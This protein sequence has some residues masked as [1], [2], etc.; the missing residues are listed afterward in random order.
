MKDI[1][2]LALKI[3]DSL[4]PTAGKG[5]GKNYILTPNNVAELCTRFLAAYTEGQEPISLYPCGFKELRRLVI[6]NGAYL[7]QGMCEG[8]PVTESIRS[9]A[10]VLIGY[11]KDM[12]ILLA[13]QPLY[14]APPEPAPRLQEGCM[15]AVTK[16]GHSICQPPKSFCQKGAAPSSEEVRE[17]VERLRYS[18]NLHEYKIM[19]DAAD[20]IESLE[21]QVVALTKERGIAKHNEQC[22]HGANKRILKELIAAQAREAK[23]REALVDYDNQASEYDGRTS[24]ELGDRIKSLLA[25]PTDDSALQDAL[26]AERGRCI[27]ACEE[28]ADIYRQ[29]HNPEAEN[30]ADACADAIRGIA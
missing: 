20:M 3:A 25:S 2:E 13:K 14:A 1:K 21:Q 10:M 6:K 17:K 30:V 5:C 28:T 24:K 7:A 8:E 18:A 4:D 27:A 23:L 9:A 26:K 15:W 11:A 19:S 29:M 12:S 22:T 16:G